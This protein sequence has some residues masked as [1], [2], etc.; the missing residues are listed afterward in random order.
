MLISGRSC[1][2]STSRVDSDSI[3]RIFK[4]LCG[5]VIGIFRRIGLEMVTFSPKKPFSDG[6]RPQV[7]RIT[8]QKS[9]RLA[10]NPHGLRKIRTTLQ[11][12]AILV[13]A[14]ARASFRM[15]WIRIMWIRIMWIRMTWIRFSSSSCRIR[16]SCHARAQGIPISPRPPLLNLSRMSDLLCET[17]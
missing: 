15:T 2:F 11:E 12:S 5:F 10:E 3:V 7:I 4:D 1:G 16:L 14:T 6:F 17:S 9:A 13:F 8:C